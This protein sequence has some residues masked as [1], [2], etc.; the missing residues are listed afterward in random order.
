MN[1]RVSGSVFALGVGLLVAWLAYTRVTDPE[2]ARQRAEEIAAV[3][4]ATASLVATLPAGG[5]VATVDPLNPNRAVGK[6]YVYPVA[7]GWEVSGYYR[8]G[9]RDTWH[10]WLMSL[11]SGHRLVSL[12][13]RDDAADIARL[14]TSD[15]RISVMP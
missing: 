12:S 13:V 3:R 15:Q 10:P 2:P 14:A 5:P 4:A 6:S 1:Q 11:D 7:D 9:E 8:R